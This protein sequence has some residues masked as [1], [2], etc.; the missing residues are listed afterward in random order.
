M[1]LGFD[2]SDTAEAPPRGA[3]SP[4]ALRRPGA[5]LGYWTVFVLFTVAVVVA[6][7]GPLYWLLVGALKSPKELAA[8]PPTLWP[9]DPQWGN[10]D[11]AWNNLDIAA[12]MT[13]TMFYAAGSVI[14]QVLVAVTA[15]FSLSYLRPMFSKPLFSLI[16]VTLFIPGVI[17]FVPLYATMVRLPLPGTEITLINSPLALWLPAGANAFNIFL[18][19]R[20]FDRLP[21]ELIQSAQID[22]A[23]SWQI[24]WH[25]VLPMS[26]P[27]LAVI[28]V[29]AFI[30]ASTD[31][32]WS[33]LVLPDP[34]KQPL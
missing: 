9:G 27:I 23:N 26:R 20:F 13:N 12:S 19:K 22:G 7:I 11:F 14:V 28:S 31:F 21:V 10:Y 4:L 6:Y 24:L 32:L 34:G 3:M 8:T 30:G 29:F 17:T 2:P 33:L 15:A 16:L 5:R 1:K 18:V 25:V